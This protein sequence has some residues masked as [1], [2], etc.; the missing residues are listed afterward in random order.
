MK[1]PL[2]WLRDYLEELPSVDDLA[3]RLT[4]AGLE[5]EAVVESDPRLVDHLRVARIAE[6][7]PHPNADRLSLCRVEDGEGERQI[8][9]GAKNMKAGVRSTLHGSPLGQG[10]L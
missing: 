3:H 10:R 5:V 2:G 1:L 9:C 7:V 4:M 6:M 8:V